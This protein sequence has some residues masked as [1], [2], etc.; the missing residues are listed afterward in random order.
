MDTNT[1][2]NGRDAS[3]RVIKERFEVRLTKEIALKLFAHYLPEKIVV[4][5]GINDEKGTLAAYTDGTLVSLGQWPVSKYPN[6][7]R[8]LTGTMAAALYQCAVDEASDSPRLSFDKDRTSDVIEGS[9]VVADNETLD[10][11]LANL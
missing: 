1:N 5:M 9:T 11:L 6:E 3:K 7:W 8:K 2:T 4:R 10:N